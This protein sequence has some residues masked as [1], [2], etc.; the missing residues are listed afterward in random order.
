MMLYCIERLRVL[1]L[2]CTHRNA[3][4]VQ[5]YNQA[6]KSRNHLV[7]SKLFVSPTAVTTPCNCITVTFP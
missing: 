1:I 3:H 2:G 4:A 7:V 6:I 5:Q